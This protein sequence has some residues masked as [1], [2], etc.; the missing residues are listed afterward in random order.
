[1]D[2]E[3]YETVFPT[4]PGS[5]TRQVP[6]FEVKVVDDEGKECEPGKAGEGEGAKGEPGTIGKIVIKRPLPPGSM[7][8]VVGHNK[9]AALK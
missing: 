4:L 2:L 7:L 5:V 3:T 1:M 8:D 9:D 6:G